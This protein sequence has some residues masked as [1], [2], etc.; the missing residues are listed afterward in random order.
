LA[1]GFCPK[2]FFPKKL[3]RSLGAAAVFSSPLA[4]T[5]MTETDLPDLTYFSLI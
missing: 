4:R 1:A 2:N 3:C 5:P